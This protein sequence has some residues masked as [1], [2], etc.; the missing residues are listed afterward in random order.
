MQR[1]I[2][3]LFSGLAALLG[4]L[5]AMAPAGV[6][7]SHVIARDH[8]NLVRVP[9]ERITDV[10]FDSEALEIQADKSRGV[11][12][13]RVKPLWAAQG[14]TQTAAFVNTAGGSSGVT[15]KVEAVPSQIVEL[16]PA[17]GAPLVPEASDAGGGVPLVRFSDSDYLTE[18]KTLVRRAQA[19][20][21]DE[22]REAGAVWSERAAEKAAPVKF[23]SRRVRWGG[24]VVR[25][26]A[27]WATADKVVEKLSVTNLAVR[28]AAIDP[29]AFAR[30]AAGTLAV[31]AEKTEL[32]TGDAADV[33]L[34]RSRQA[35]MDAARAAGRR[36]VVLAGDAIADAAEVRVK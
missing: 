6:I 11:V 3:P 27:V 31:A 15:F 25:E 30:A 33:I 21:F 22:P 29:A 19:E 9:G 7:E 36:G 35:A 12:F 5:P 24:L 32:M 28:T 10:V 4:F 1:I 2:R 18:L 13:V 23:K 14:N 26:A 20:R 16:A 17:K 8:V 34:I